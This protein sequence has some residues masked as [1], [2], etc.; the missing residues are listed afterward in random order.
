[1]QDK[2]E[3]LRVQLQSLIQKRDQ[4]NVLIDTIVQTIAYREGKQD[5]KDEKNLSA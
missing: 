2:V 3:P 5:M 4:Y 1:M